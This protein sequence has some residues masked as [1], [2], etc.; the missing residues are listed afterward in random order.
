[1]KTNLDLY[2]NIHSFSKSLKYSSKFG[3]YLEDI[4]GSKLS[5]EN[6]SKIQNFTKR[7][8]NVFVF[9]VK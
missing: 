8:K 4:C 5:K 1:M 3:E 7:L 9:L 6:K 2:L